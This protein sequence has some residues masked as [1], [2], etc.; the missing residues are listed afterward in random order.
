[1]F[2]YAYAYI[3]A[4]YL[5]KDS[6]MTD[7]ECI[8]EFDL[9]ITHPAYRAMKE[10][11]WKVAKDPETLCGKV[12]GDQKVKFD[13][14][15]TMTPGGDEKNVKADAENK[16]WGSF[17]DSMEKEMKAHFDALVTNDYHYTGLYYSY[18]N[19]GCINCIEKSIRRARTTAF[20]SLVWAEGLRAYCSRSFEQPVW[21]NLFKNSH[22]N[23]AVGMAQFT[24]VLALFIP[25]LN[26]EVLGLY[27]YEIQGFGWFLAFVGAFACL[28]FCELYKFFTS[29]FI[30]QAELANYEED[31]SG[32]A[33]TNT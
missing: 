6:S 4:L 5:E 28:F 3:S 31:E 13:D 11:H 21:V 22:M 30:G 7:Y 29:R 20:V 1:M 26:T 25:G 33:K 16:A 15:L 24:L 19:T 23:Y 32:M 12:C 8:V 27:V 18:E 17:E 2:I 9:I 10:Y 14:F